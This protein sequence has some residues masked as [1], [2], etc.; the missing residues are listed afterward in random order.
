MDYRSYQ[1]HQQVPNSGIQQQND[2]PEYSNLPQPRAQA[3]LASA[4]AA[5]AT[6][7]SFNSKRS[8]HSSLWSLQ[9]EQD[10]SCGGELD[11]N[12]SDMVNYV[13]D[14]FNANGVSSTEYSTLIMRDHHDTNIPARSAAF[15]NSSR[16]S[17]SNEALN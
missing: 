5:V 1:S 10:P 2:M 8:R 12:N 17:A 14:P 9:D 4:A 13:N 16:H 6:S 15:H 11:H 3:S 7:S